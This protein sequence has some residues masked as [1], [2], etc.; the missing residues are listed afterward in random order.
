MQAMITSLS[1]SQNSNK[2]L[3]GHSATLCSSYLLAAASAHW[4]LHLEHV[5]TAQS[6]LLTAALAH[7]NLRLDHV[8]ITSSQLLA[9][10]SA[11][12]KLHLGHVCIARLWP[13]VPGGWQMG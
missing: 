13:A 10:A 12:W 2:Q 7:R 8:C 11:R 4:E 3:P 9:A 6:Q 5:R 1:S